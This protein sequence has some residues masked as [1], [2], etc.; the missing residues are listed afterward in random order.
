MTKYFIGAVGSLLGILA[1]AWL[2]LA[3][4]ALAYQ[5]DGAGWVDATKVD[6]WSGA[7][8]ILLSVAGLI[9]FIFSLVEE[10]RNMGVIERKEKE[11]TEQEEAP[12]A[13]E[14]EEPASQQTDVEQVLLPLVNAMLKDMQDQQRREGEAASQNNNS[15]NLREDP[16][17]SAR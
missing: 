9:M 17:R 1:G 11:E 4:T 14:A 5:P 8:L 10:L 6:F 13:A 12:E 7:G 15:G 16:E 3:P 2:M